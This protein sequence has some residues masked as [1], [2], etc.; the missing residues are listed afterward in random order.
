MN[1]RFNLVFQ[2]FKFLN[3]IIFMTTACFNQCVWSKY[4][5]NYSKVVN[6]IALDTYTA[7]A[8]VFAA[9]FEGSQLLE[10]CFFRG[11]KMCII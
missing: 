8:A 7:F 1:T 11:A 5:C 3:K 6:I 2:T 9:S 4:K 10:I